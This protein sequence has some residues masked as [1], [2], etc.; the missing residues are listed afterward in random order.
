MFKTVLVGSALENSSNEFE[1]SLYG[2]RDP[3]MEAY[4]VWRPTV[5]G[6]R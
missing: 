6:H 3:I 4:E 2:P 5:D 1:A